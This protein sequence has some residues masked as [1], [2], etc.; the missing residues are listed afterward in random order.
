MGNGCTSLPQESRIQMSLSKSYM[1][2]AACSATSCTST[3]TLASRQ[4]E[5]G[6]RVKTTWSLAIH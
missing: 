1:D 6:T 2:A 4:E 3:G 5:S